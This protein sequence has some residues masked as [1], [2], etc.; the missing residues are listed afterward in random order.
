MKGRAEM[1]PGIQKH[2]P[3]KNIS[4]MVNRKSDHGAVGRARRRAQPPMMCDP[5]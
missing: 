1:R 5:D 3:G 4:R 2:H